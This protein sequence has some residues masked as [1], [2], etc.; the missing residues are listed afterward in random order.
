MEY[1]DAFH[2]PVNASASSSSP[3]PEKLL[4]SVTLVAKSLNLDTQ[5]FVIDAKPII[6]PRELREAK[7]YGR[8]LFMTLPRREHGLYPP[9]GSEIRVNERQPMAIVSEQTLNAGQSTM[10][11]LLAPEVVA[12]IDAFNVA[13]VN[14]P[15]LATFPHASYFA[16][17]PHLS[18]QL[19]F[20]LVPLL[21]LSEKRRLEFHLKGADEPPPTVADQYCLGLQLWQMSGSY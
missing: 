11:G 8:I 15:V 7:W 3:P 6:A 1:F 5:E 2:S 19:R 21:P 13:K 12:V 20:A 18:E 10:G 4:Y 16:L 17:K 14:S 9:A